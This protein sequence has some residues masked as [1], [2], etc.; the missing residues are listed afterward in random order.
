[1]H[2]P[3]LNEPPVRRAAAGGS[4]ASDALLQRYRL[5]REAC[6]TEWGVLYDA[7]EKET[8]RRVSIE[9]ANDLDEEERARFERDGMMAQRLEGEHVLH[10]LEAG[11]LLDGT[12]YLVREPALGS[13]AADVDAGGPLPTGEA[14]ALTLEVCEALAEAH[15]RGMAHGDVRADTVF[16]ARDAEGNPIA[17]LRWTSRAKAERAAREDVARDIAAAALLLRYLITGQRDLEDDG[18]KTLP[19]DLGYAVARATAADD[20]SRFRNIGELA[21]AISRYAPPGHTA[22]RNIAFLLSRAGIIGG[23]SSGGPS[24]A[25]G[26]GPIHPRVLSQPG[27]NDAWFEPRP[28]LTSVPPS[29][30][31]RSATFAIVSLVLLA[32]TFAGTVL[33]W[34]SGHLPQW[35]GTAPTMHED[36]LDAVSRTTL[37]AAD[38][39]ETTAITPPVL[40]TTH[41]TQEGRSPVTAG[42]RAGNGSIREPSNDPS[43]EPARAATPPAGTAAIPPASAGQTT[44]TPPDRVGSSRT[45]DD[46]TSTSKAKSAPTDK[47]AEPWPGTG[48]LPPSTST[49]PTPTPGTTDSSSAGATSPGSDLTSPA[50]E[51][52]APPATPAPLPNDPGF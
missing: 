23:L 26:P 8:L 14:V 27:L 2:T 17:K 22:A 29:A 50:T 5:E 40:L 16:L 38:V 28:S 12:R 51:P 36:R 49:T 10:V 37:T 7:V 11:A 33:L 35:S 19:S 15:T 6:R 9:I 41:S 32:A 20:V 39:G 48:A 18:A 13:L 45:D 4:A 24:V 21:A 47:P 1:M 25:G 46:V 44:A 30:P 34:K 3:L 31:R 42:E 52:T 43:S